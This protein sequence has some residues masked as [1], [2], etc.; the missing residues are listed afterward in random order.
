LGKPVVVH[1]LD[2]AMEAG[3]FSEVVCLTDSS[4]I[5]ETVSAYGHRFILSGDAANGTERIARNLDSIESDLVVNLQGDEPA[6]PIEGLQTLREALCQNPEWMH[7]LVHE[8]E[9]S[10]QD[11][12][13]PNRVKA[14]LDANGFV[15]DFC[16]D[17]RPSARTENAWRLHLGAYAYSKN[18]LRRYAALPSSKREV[19]ESHEILRDLNLAP[20]RAHA[21]QPGAPVDTPADLVFARQ[22]LEALALQGAL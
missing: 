2:R 4:E 18:F 1:A 22:R 3:C 9:T 19:E 13:N 11:L 7:T 16:R 21:S 14:I 10:E 20:I 8:E 6:F 5:G 12:E 17:G 15:L